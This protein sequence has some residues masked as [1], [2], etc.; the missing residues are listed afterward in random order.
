VRL[1]L[2]PAG[3]ALTAPSSG[4]VRR[5]VAPAVLLDLYPTSRRLLLTTPDPRIEH[6]VRTAYRRS[7]VSEELVPGAD[8]AIVTVA[9]APAAATFNGKPLADPGIVRDARSPWRSG[10]Y[11]VDQCVWRA[12][13]ADGDWDPIYGCAV[14]VG[15]RAVL[16]VGESGV[17]K[18]TLCLAL[19]RL[20]AAI[21]GDEM[22]LVH[23]RTRA[24]TAIPRALTIHVGSFALF[25]DDAFCRRIRRRAVPVEALANGVSSVDARVLGPPPAPVTLR[26][27]VIVKRG[28]G[29]TKLAPL[30]PA[31]AAMML[32]PHLAE[33]P[34]D[35]SAVGRVAARLSSIA[36]FRLTLERPGAAAAALVE[37][38]SQC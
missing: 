38:L 36:A 24:V 3:D 8:R 35:L 4:A 6:Y 12:L 14:R 5:S 20:G 21:Y 19:S 17:G 23:R 30:R 33:R 32:A 11:L 10:A 29:D 34:S 26:A 31:H 9:P 7:I 25:D 2:P 1:L 22:V 15:N 18:T 28:S 16:I 13:R 37:G 27:V